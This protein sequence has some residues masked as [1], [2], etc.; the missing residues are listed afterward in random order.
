MSHI[1][2]ALIAYL[3]DRLFGDVVSKKHPVAYMRDY[4]TWFEEHYYEESFERGV[5]LLLSL[6]FLAVAL[7]YP[8]VTY[9]S[10]FAPFFTV[11]LSGI[12]A[13]LFISHKTIIK[14]AKTASPTREAY[15]HELNTKV[16][17]PL[18]YLLLFGLYGVVIY[19]AIRTLESMTKEQNMRYIRF[20]SF[21][22]QLFG[23]LNFPPQK[24]IALSAKMT[25]R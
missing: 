6:V 14:A 24:L 10:F 13:S 18:L 15:H 2:V 16:I 9:L 21:S 11:L 12:L 7:T 5:L 3:L 23:W 8:V 25:N 1:V 20:G 17:A 19:T 22:S 4:I